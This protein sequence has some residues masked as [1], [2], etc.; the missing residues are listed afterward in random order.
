MSEAPTVKAARLTQTKKCEAMTLDQLEHEKSS[1]DTLL[2]NVFQEWS[3]RHETIMLIM[4]RLDIVRN[5]I[6][7]KKNASF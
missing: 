2:T 5:F 6:S 7:E 4:S 3:D 1:L